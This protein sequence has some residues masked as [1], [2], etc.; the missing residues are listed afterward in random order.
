M[1]AILSILL[2]TVFALAMMPGCATGG[3][4][5]SKQSAGECTVK[6]GKLLDASGSP[7]TGCVMMHNGKMMVM[8]GKLVPV[9]KNMTMPDGTLCM[10]DGTCVM[11]GGAKRKLQEGEVITPKGDIFHAKGLATPGGHF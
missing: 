6:D 9:K 11:K 4:H 7:M 1:K 5:A 10:V 2:S 8:N 3:N